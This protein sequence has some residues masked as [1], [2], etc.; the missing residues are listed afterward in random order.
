[1][2]ET[3]RPASGMLRLPLDRGVEVCKKEGALHR[4]RWLVKRLVG[5][6]AASLGGCAK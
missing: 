4:C 5:E 3:G 2:S 6:G 1:M